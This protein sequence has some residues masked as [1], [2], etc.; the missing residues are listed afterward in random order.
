[1]GKA[2]LDSAAVVDNADTEAL[3]VKLDQ[4]IAAN[5][6]FSGS[7]L[8]SQSGRILVNKGHGMANAADNIVNTS[9]TKFL[10]G[11]VTKQFTAMAVMLLYAKG[12]LDLDIGFQNTCLIFRVG[13]R[14]S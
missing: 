7:V 6:G 10:I 12:L 14:L 9:A 3:S 1:M 8:V 13:M 2:L 4:I 5:I 11:S